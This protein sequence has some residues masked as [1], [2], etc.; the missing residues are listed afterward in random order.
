MV[1]TKIVSTTKSLFGFGLYIGK[2]RYLYLLSKVSVF[3]DSGDTISY[4]LFT[5]VKNKDKG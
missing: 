2:G 4:C 1:E 3:S 5:V